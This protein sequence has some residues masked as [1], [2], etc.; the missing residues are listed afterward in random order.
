MNRKGFTLIELLAVIL[1]LG[2]VGGIAI[3][4]GISTI[5]KSKLKSEK[6][7][8]DKLS[9]FI[10]D[11]L[12]LNPPKIKEKDTYTFTKCEDAYCQ[13]SYTAVAQKMLKKDG[14][15]ITIAD[16]VQ[17][18]IVTYEDLFNPKNHKQCFSTT[19]N[20]EI[21]V[22]KDSD[23]VSYYYVD[24]KNNTCELA[25]ENSTINT[26]PDNLKSEVNFS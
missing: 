5:N 23:Y 1:I 26:L 11:Y 18:K 17:E 12:D 14:T 19:N 6:I 25:I 13:N 15:P 2:V 10:D 22:Y 16:L 7:F 24:L 9:N 21:I 3:Y 20:P 8:I 4:S